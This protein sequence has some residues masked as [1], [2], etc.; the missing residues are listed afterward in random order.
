M[1]H[2]EREAAPKEREEDASPPK[3]AEEHEGDEGEEAL[4]VKVRPLVRPVRP[5]GVLAD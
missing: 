3:R 2:A 5:R 4:H 1:D